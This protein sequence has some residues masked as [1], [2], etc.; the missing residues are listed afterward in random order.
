MGDEEKIIIEGDVAGAWGVDGH[1]VELA[2]QVG[3]HDA[4]QDRGVDEQELNHYSLKDA[5]DALPCK[6][7]MCVGGIF[8]VWLKYN[9]NSFC[10]NF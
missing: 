6:G 3:E 7:C 1:E 9:S 5:W 4:F 10:F 2:E 8:E